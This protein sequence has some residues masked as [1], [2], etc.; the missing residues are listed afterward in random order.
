MGRLE[1]K[2]L[3][4]ALAAW[5]MLA[6]GCANVVYRGPVR[7]VGEETRKKT[8]LGERIDLD[9]LVERGGL[10]PVL[11]IR[12]VKVREVTLQ[13]RPL[14]REYGYY[15]PFNPAVKVVEMV[16]FPVYL[17][18]GAALLYRYWTFDE[19]DGGVG[20]GLP[21]SEP[22]EPVALEDA[23]WRVLA[24]DLDAVVRDPA[25]HLFDGSSFEVMWN[26]WAL[27]GEVMDP[28]GNAR[29]PI[30]GRTVWGPVGPVIEGPWVEEKRLEKETL[31]RR[32]PTIR[33]SGVSVKGTEDPSGYLL[34]DLTALGEGPLKVTVELPLEGGGK[35][36]KT[37]ELDAD[38]LAAVKEA[39]KLRAVLAASPGDVKT[40]KALARLHSSFGGVAEAMHILE[41]AGGGAPADFASE[42]DSVYLSEARR[43]HDEGDV[44]AALGADALRVFH[45]D[46]LSGAHE[47]W[48]ERIRV[49]E[50][51]LVEGLGSTSFL[52][53][54]RSAVILADRNDVSKDLKTAALL[55]LLRNETN[56]VARWAILFGLERCGNEGA[57]TLQALGEEWEDPFIRYRAERA[58]GAIRA[59][60]GEER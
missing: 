3:L 43:A 16:S 18:I 47:N 2:L 6:T 11:R 31:R 34:L 51:V 22:D 33:I 8:D 45:G 17:G 56:I 36:E 27:L 54:A 37:V 58:S 38:L 23:Q 48:E 52:T 32:F 55:A 30:D 44:P 59:R 4:A 53:R 60:L 14:Y 10:S 12:P 35:V 28:F 50:R 1:S 39:E 41:G 19:M 42:F 15:I 21:V 40:R 9:L 7:K 24:A 57:G 29:F 20:I 49:S 25:T 5:W 26:W 13:S 46:I